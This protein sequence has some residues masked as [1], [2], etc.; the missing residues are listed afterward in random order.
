M[1]RDSKGKG[2]EIQHIEE[3]SDEDDEAI[4]SYSE[5]DDE[6]S[7]RQ[8]VGLDLHG[9]MGDGDSLSSTTSSQPRTP[10]DSVFMDHVPSVK[11]K[12]VPG[13]ARGVAF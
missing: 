11:G 8:A 3:A 13:R 2:K 5:S 4:G 10:E 6:R 7:G 12:E 1:E 9:G